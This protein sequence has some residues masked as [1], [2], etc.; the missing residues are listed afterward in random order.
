MVATNTWAAQTGERHTNS[1]VPF[2][3]PWLGSSWSSFFPLVSENG[4]VIWECKEF[5]F[6]LLQWWTRNGQFFWG[7]GAVRE[8]CRH[9]CPASLFQLLYK[10]I[11]TFLCFCREPL[12]PVRTLLEPMSFNGGWLGD[13]QMHWQTKMVPKSQTDRHSVIWLMKTGKF[14]TFLFWQVSS[15]FQQLI[16]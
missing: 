5:Q 14:K 6:Q 2:S 8:V 11:N 13:R 1:P 15:L 4:F 3:Q 10:L 16:G 9:K 12:V 7:W